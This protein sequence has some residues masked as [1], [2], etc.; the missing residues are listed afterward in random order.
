MGTVGGRGLH[1]Q[2]KKLDQ[3][4]RAT[5]AEWNI[6]AW[7]DAKFPSP[8]AEDLHIAIGA[9]NSPALAKA[10]HRLAL[11]PLLVAPW[12][13]DPEVRQKVAALR[14]THA[15]RVVRQ[16]GFPIFCRYALRLAWDEVAPRPGANLEFVGH[17]LRTRAMAHLVDFLDQVGDDPE[18]AAH[19][20]ET[21]PVRD[22]ERWLIGVL[23]LEKALGPGWRRRRAIM[24]GS[25][26]GALRTWRWRRKRRKTVTRPRRSIRAK[27]GS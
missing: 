13:A 3:E 26:P 22:R 2:G 20:I 5:G 24:L 14:H 11:H 19:V 10:L 7:D 15:G 9:Q 18:S 17:E 6:G 1:K 16:D 27:S 25:T 21:R 8:L 12:V 23:D 4:L